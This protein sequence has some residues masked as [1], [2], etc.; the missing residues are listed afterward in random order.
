VLRTITVICATRA[1]G[2][3]FLILRSGREEEIAVDSKQES[4]QEPHRPPE[5]R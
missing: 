5:A 3:P 1:V 2:L 4:W